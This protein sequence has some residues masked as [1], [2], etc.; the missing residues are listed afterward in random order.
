MEIGEKLCEVV[1]DALVTR[2][3]TFQSFRL[4]RGQLF[5]SLRGRVQAEYT[6]TETALPYP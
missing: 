6:S 1:I 4:L 3:C 2:R 5:P